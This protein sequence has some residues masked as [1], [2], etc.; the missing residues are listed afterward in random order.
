MGQRKDRGEQSRLKIVRGI[1]W[2]EQ[3]PSANVP[4]VQP[5]RTF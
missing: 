4:V 3:V 1:M 2:H 5:G